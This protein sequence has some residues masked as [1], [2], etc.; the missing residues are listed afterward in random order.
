MIRHFR[1]RGRLIAWAMAA[2]VA[3]CASQSRPDAA[4]WRD[5][6]VVGL[7]HQVELPPRVDRDCLEDADPRETHRVV[8]VN[9]RMSRRAPFYKQAFPL[10][11]GETW[12]LGQHVQVDRSTCRIRSSDAA[13]WV[14]DTQDE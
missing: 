13:S 1:M 5:G 11:A 3:G 6:T 2:G 9:F 12:S 7:L 4:N 8:V 10:A 14:Q